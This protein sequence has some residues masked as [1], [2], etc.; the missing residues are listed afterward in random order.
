MVMQ[1]EQHCAVH[2]LAVLSLRGAFTNRLHVPLC[3]V[4]HQRSRLQIAATGSGAAT[5]A[6]LVHTSAAVTNSDA[7]GA[8]AI[9]DIPVPD[10]DAASQQIGGSSECHLIRDSP[11]QD[12]QQ[13][14]EQQAEQPPAADR[15]LQ[16]QQQ[17]PQQPETWPQAPLPQVVP[18]GALG[19]AVQAANLRALQAGLEAAAETDDAEAQQRHRRCS[20]DHS[21]KYQH[22]TFARLI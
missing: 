4:Q 1:Q 6:A 16:E 11:D 17:L 13:Q 18:A 19:F 9:D 5:H 20:L 7:L 2:R 8:A 12:E 22:L 14:A 10:L 21:S 15:V 3:R